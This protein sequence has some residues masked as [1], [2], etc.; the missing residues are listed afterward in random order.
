MGEAAAG[1]HGGVS[2]RELVVLGTASQVPTRHRNHNGY[3]LRFD[4]V[5]L[6]FDPGEGTQRQMTIAGVPVPHVTG[7]C[8]T[9]FH[10]DH[11]LGLPG[12]VQRL[13][14]D[15]ARHTV[16]VCYPESGQMFFDRLRHASQFDD[17]ASL[18]CHPLRDAP[19]LLP[20]RGLTVRALPLVHRVESWGYR[21][22]EPDGRTLVPELLADA[23][24]EG[25][26]IGEL[27]RTG[28]YCVAGRVLRLEEVSVERRGQVVAFIMDTGLCTNAL[29]LARGADLLVCESTFLESEADLAIGYGHLTARQAATLARDAGVRSLVLTHF[30]QRHPDERVFLEEAK[31]VF[32]GITVAAHDGLR[33]PVP[34]R[35]RGGEGRR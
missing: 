33:I 28:E 5:G 12:I 27:Q 31:E 29:E 8:I 23:G 17:R 21:V 2:V 35:I 19:A 26:A 10:G 20:H 30:S 1:Q 25:P 18:A 9:H 14:L 15:G 16:D 11:C 6:L 24:I 22:E 32:S 3:F 7:I 13:S 34:R 4:D